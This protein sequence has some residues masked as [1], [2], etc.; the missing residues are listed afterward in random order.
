MN[1]KSILDTHQADGE[2]GS[3]GSGEHGPL[4]SSPKPLQETGDTRAPRETSRRP[5]LNDRRECNVIQ[6]PHRRESYLN[7]AVTISQVRER[8]AIQM[9]GMVTVLRNWLNWW[10]VNAERAQM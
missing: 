6:P 5:R 1:L 4:Q 10:Y 9:Q 3:G 2:H 8:T 7:M